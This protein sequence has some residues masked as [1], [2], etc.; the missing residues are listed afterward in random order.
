MKIRRRNLCFG[1]LA[2]LLAG[3]NVGAQTAEYRGYRVCTKCHVAQG[4]AWRKTG[5]A[6]AF[7]S[8]KPNVK[9]S[10]KSKAGLDPAKDYT[11][12]SDCVGCHV[13]GYGESGG[14]EAGMNPDNAKLVIGLIGVTC[15][16]CHGAG[17]NYRQK[18]ADAGDRL[19]RSGEATDREVLVDAR[20]NFDYE[21]AC[22][23]CHLNH[24]GS[25]WV[26]TKPPY[27]PFTPAVDAKYQFDFDKAVRAF[28]DK[29]PAHTHY[30]LRGVFKG[31]TVP[32]IRAEI[33]QSAQEEPE[34]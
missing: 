28:G 21:N 8:L 23:R 33:Q 32:A 25:K 11:M 30:R 1:L 4:D 16:A 34:E 7:D 26:G 17:S 10:A 3:S 14:Y 22:A 12:D 15:E 29:N 31:G 13:T 27:T 2:T 24:S 6:K 18:H 19:K 5:H 20:Q 9:A